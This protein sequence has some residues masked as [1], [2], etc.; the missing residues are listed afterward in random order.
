MSG[1]MKL[2]YVKDYIKSSSYLWEI[3]FN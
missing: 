1:A 3:I 2:E